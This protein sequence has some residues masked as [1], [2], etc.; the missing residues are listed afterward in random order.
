MPLITLL[1]QRSAVD[2]FSDDRDGLVE[3]L[4][5]I[6]KGGAPWPPTTGWLVTA[7]GGASRAE[8]ISN[9]AATDTADG[10][11]AVVYDDAAAPAAACVADHILSERD[12]SQKRLG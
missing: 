2:A 8:Q 11:D 10:D 9:R 6:G 7:L 4:G 5:F 12:L 3:P 1:L